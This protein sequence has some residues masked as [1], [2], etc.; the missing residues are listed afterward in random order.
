MVVEYA[1]YGN[2]RDFL[3]ERRPSDTG[4]EAP[5]T[6]PQ[7]DQM[8]QLTFKDLISFAFQVSRGME[9]LSSKQVGFIDCHKF[10]MN[11]LLK[12]E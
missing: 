7:D 8:R 2:L 4:Y 9:Y 12:Y 3:R 10:A 1:M 5:I 6:P 11:L